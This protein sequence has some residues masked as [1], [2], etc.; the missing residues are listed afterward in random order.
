M[1]YISNF[2]LAHGC[3]KVRVNSPYFEAEVLCNAISGTGSNSETSVMTCSY[4][5]L[6]IRKFKDTKAICITLFAHTYFGHCQLDEQENDEKKNNK[7]TIC[8]MYYSFIIFLLSGFS[9]SI[10]F[11]C[12][13]LIKEK[14]RGNRK[15]VFYH[16]NHNDQSYPTS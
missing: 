9:S 3:P 10:A 11:K 16:S 4:K 5:E 14:I 8:D 2:V 1:L 12:L 15:F 13:N 6:F 7:M